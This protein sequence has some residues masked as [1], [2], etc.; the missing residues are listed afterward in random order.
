MALHE[1]DPG[2]LGGYRIVDRLGSGGMGV[3]YRARAGSGREVAVKVVH[4]QYAEDPVFRVRFRQ[5]IAAVRRV[6][7]AFTAPVV[8]ADPEAPRPWMATQYVPGRPLSARVRDDGP[9]AG[10]ELRRLVLGLVE[11][12]RDIHRSGVVH[13][14][15]KPANVL[16]AEDGPRVIDFGISRAAENQALTETGH[17][18]GT[19]P[20]MSPEQLAD[21][22]SVGPASDVFSLA[23]L[24]VF[25][26]TGRG[27]F[28]ADSPYLTAYRVMTEEPDLT[29]VPEPLRTVL[30]RCLA[31]RSAA[32]PGLDA[33]AAEFAAALPEPAATEPPTAPHRPTDPAPTRPPA[34]VP[35][36]TRAPAVAPDPTWPPAAGLEPTRAPV[37]DPPRPPAQDPPRPSA[38][39]QTRAPAVAPDP[40]WPPAAGLAPS[41]PPAQ[42][43]TGPSAPDRARTPQDPTGPSAPDRARTRPPGPGPDRPRPPVAAPD[44]T[45]PR[46]ADL[47]PP[48]LPAADPPAPVPYRADAPADPAH[49]AVDAADDVAGIPAAGPTASVPYP[50]AAH[51]DPARAAA[52]ATG[53]PVSRT[54]GLRVPLAVGVAGVLV[55]ALTAYLFGP[56][57]V[58]ARPGAAPSP[59]AE[60]TRWGA[61]PAG[62]RPWRTTM[63]A[64]AA[65]G[66]KRSSAPAD[67]PGHGGQPS[68]ALSGG[69]LYCGGDTTLPIRV[70]AVTGRTVWRAATR[71]PGIALGRYGSA[72][73][74]VRDGVV[75][76][77][78]SV[79]NVAAED[80][81][82]TVTAFAAGDGRRLWSRPT[83]DAN[84]QA[85]LV[86]GLVLVP[87]GLTVTARSPRDGSARWTMSVPAGHHCGFHGA[88]G[89]VYADCTGYH[90]P[91]GARR[92]L[93]ALDPAD[94]AARPLPA[95]PS[96]TAE[97]AGTLDGRL[98][99][100]ARR[101]GDPTTQDNPYTGVEVID[102]RTGARATHAL[103]GEYRGR[104]AMAHGVLCFAASDGGT[105]AVSPL[106]G[107]RVW[108]TATTLEQPAAPVADERGSVFLASASGRVAALDARTGR[109][110]WES[111]PRAGTVVSGDYDSPE[112]LV[113]GGALVVTTPDGTLFTLDPA[114]PGRAPA[115]A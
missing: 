74:G 66:V 26:A 102:P 6:S 32:R 40:T 104:V 71:P 9:L 115:P 54:R 34:A 33:L 97:Y 11:A 87:D 55:V 80:T 43:P 46:V 67:G 2:S 93:I 72:V 99:Y 51:G 5:E 75:L 49:A 53:V 82:T 35:A 56:F 28:D 30:S 36:P 100:A 7:G 8:D 76:V 58:G 94:G 24:V 69:A 13:R 61:L 4:A 19:P 38:P 17:M 96:L 3:V 110:L 15:L 91:S 52:G 89:D 77:R 70:D 12:L 22:R 60:A 62:W 65:H 45:R 73:V 21:A 42:D 57:Q 88:G 10:A 103:A 59:S 111:Y 79:L 47:E 29:A 68:C 50:A 85:V 48:R 95:A 113:N 83:G 20:F 107:R 31:K 18:M 114:R 14:D 86:G 23:A 78:E 64:V 101:S 25:A 27:P 63:Y 106:T 37:V 92:R 109:R 108:R 112:L 16:M 41:R 44:P 1:G 98:V 90:T 39:D 81:T 84:A 105:T